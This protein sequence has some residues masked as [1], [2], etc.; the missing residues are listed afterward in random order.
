MAT[1]TRA[2]ASSGAASTAAPKRP[3]SG[4]KGKKAAT[5]TRKGSSPARSW[6][7]S[8]RAWLASFVKGLVPDFA[9]SERLKREGIGGLLVLLALC[10]SWALGRGRQD[11]AVIAWWSD[12][13]TSLFHVAAPL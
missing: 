2:R 7:S 5:G 12:S 9:V 1:Q 8:V 4:S 11:G 3:A 13:L 6:L 10:S